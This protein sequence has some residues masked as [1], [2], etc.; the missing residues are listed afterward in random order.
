VAGEVA[1]RD[2]VSETPRDKP[3]AQLGCLGAAV[4]EQ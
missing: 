2:Y 3:S 4:L 1:V